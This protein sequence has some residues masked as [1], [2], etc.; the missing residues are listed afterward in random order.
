[1]DQVLKLKELWVPSAL[2]HNDRWPLFKEFFQGSKVG[3]EYFRGKA[4]AIQEILGVRY[5]S[6]AHTHNADIALIGRPG[7]CKKS[8]YVNSGTWIKIFA[9]TYEERLLK[10]ENEFAYVN[11]SFEPAG[12]DVRME[13]LRWNDS[14]GEGERIRLFEE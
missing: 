7:T 12:D 14:I 13:L 3:N 10:S 1:L 6:L 8:E 9:E 5:V 4:K 2:H 11:F